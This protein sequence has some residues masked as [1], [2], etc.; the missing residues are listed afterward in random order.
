[1][2]PE[3]E[4]AI[5]KVA[6]EVWDVADPEKTG[7]LNMKQTQTLL[8]AWQQIDGNPPLSIQQFTRFWRD[9]DVNCDDRISKE[10]F[11][12]FVKLCILDTYEQSTVIETVN[13]AWDKYDINK[14]GFLE[15]D[16]VLPLVDDILDHN[17]YSKASRQ[18][19]LDEFFEAV[20]TNEDGI[21]SKQEFAVY[22]KEMLS[23][24]SDE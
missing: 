8:D 11:T 22:F 9:F 5:T 6:N 12:K 24:Q 7:Y 19:N 3:A 18:E 4:L 20:D 14:S 13:A 16:E 17:N 2:P 15:R 23:E 10:E 1:M 21:I